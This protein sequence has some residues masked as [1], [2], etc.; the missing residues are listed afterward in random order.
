M[1]MENP[2][3]FQIVCVCGG[4]EGS[5]GGG[6]VAHAAPTPCSYAYIEYKNLPL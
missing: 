5:E 2:S 4:G 3:R 1:S 6:V